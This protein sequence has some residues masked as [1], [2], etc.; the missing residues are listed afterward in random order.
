MSNH[1]MLG[2]DSPVR[3]LVHTV[4][5]VVGALVIG[6]AIHLS[7]VTGEQALLAVETLLMVG[8]GTAAV[9]IGYAVRPSPRSIAT[10]DRGSEPSGEADDNTFDSDLSPVGDE[11]EAVEEADRS[12]RNA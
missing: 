3:R 1:D 5:V 11:L 12:D 9:G 8:G 6:Q 7:V 4:F 2:P 10:G